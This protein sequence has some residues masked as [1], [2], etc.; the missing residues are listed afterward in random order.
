MFYLINVV[1]KVA[2]NTNISC[3]ASTI[4]HIWGARLQLRNWNSF[5]YKTTTPFGYDKVGTMN[6]IRE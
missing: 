5:H 3:L 1:Y 6:N 4:L 2:G